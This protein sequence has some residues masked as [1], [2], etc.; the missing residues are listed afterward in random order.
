MRN[1][2]PKFTYIGGLTALLELAG[3][4]TQ[5]SREPR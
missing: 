4:R 2:Q 1:V 5:F 3:L